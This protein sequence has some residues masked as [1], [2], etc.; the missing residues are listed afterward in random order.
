[1]LGNGSDELID[2]LS[3]AC[4][5]KAGR[6]PGA[7]T[8]LRDV[9]DVGAAAGPALH[10]RVAD[11]GVR[12]RR[13]QRCWRPSSANVRRSTYIA[14][15][16]NPTCNL[17]DD[18][19]IDRIVAAVGAQDGLVVFDEAYQPFSS[20]TWMH[21]HGRARS[22]A[23][24]AHAEQVRPGRRAP[25][26]SVRPRRADRRGREGAPALQRER[27][28]RRGR[29][30]RAGARRRVRAPGRHPARRARA[31]CKCVARAAGRAA[32][33]QRGQHDPGARARCEA[34]A[35]TA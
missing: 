5:V 18:A 13:R 19:V 14:Y 17:W 25:G 1:M 9:P 35:S 31:T 30:V 26:L 8:G 15:P 21:R 3:V 34:R 20:R 28:Q 29:A 4:N 23:G 16:N 22:C 2:M 6:D 10:R 24:D 12:A 11:A 32:V 33:S 7:R 27:A